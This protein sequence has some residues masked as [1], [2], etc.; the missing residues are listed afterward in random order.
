MKNSPAHAREA[1][2]PEFVTDQSTVS[3]LAT[4]G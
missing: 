1:V 4:S 3:M 2:F